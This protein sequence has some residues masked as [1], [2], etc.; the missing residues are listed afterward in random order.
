MPQEQNEA[1]NEFSYSWEERLILSIS[2]LK[3]GYQ[4]FIDE[5]RNSKTAGDITQSE[6][7]H[8]ARWY[9]NQ[10]QLFNSQ[11]D[12]IERITESDVLPL[13]RQVKQIIV[14]GIRLVADERG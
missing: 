4:A 9:L 11:L 7:K 1:K 8:H 3:L 12:K 14:R 13:V 10:I 6:Y 2:A 5:L